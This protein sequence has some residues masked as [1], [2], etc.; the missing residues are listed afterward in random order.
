MLLSHLC[1]VETFKLFDRTSCPEEAIF[2]FGL[3]CLKLVRR[4]GDDGHFLYEES[5]LLTIV[6]GN[7]IV[8]GNFLDDIK[9]YNN[10]LRWKY[11][12]TFSESTLI[13]PPFYAIYAWSWRK[14]RSSASSFI[15][16]LIYQNDESASKLLNDESASKLLKWWCAIRFFKL[17]ELLEGGYQI[18]Q[19]SS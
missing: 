2:L 10:P 17:G 16:D 7:L 15:M 12:L 18:Q 9:P 13:F 11:T 8:W 6:W 14:I 3:I 4:F 19:G 1:W 5:S